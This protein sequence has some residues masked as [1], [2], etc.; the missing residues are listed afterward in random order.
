[1]AIKARS[2]D[3]LKSFFAESGNNQQNNQPR[4]NNYYPFWDMKVGDRVVVRFLP[5]LDENNPRG[6][7]VE[8]VYHRLEINGR[9]ET[10]PSLTMYGEQCP[11]SQVAADYYNAGDKVNG[12]K[13]YKKRQHIGQVLIVEDPLPPNAQGETNEGKVKLITISYQLYNIIKEAFTSGELDANPTDF[14]D[15]YDFIIKKTQ[16]GEY[17]NYTVGTNFARKP[18]ALTDEEIIAAEEGIIDLKTVLPKNPGREYIERMLAA[19]LNGTEVAE[20]E[21]EEFEQPASPRRSSKPS[22]NEDVEDTTAAIES[23]TKSNAKASEEANDVND[24]LAAIRARR[25]G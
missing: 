16:Q 22:L 8:R 7:L 23:R 25:R 4:E 20:S 3:Q 19:A 14:V 10:V 9:I 5:D 11:I 24:V 12:S 1:M 17:A 6:F 18:R 15:G 21:D 13:Y 2:I